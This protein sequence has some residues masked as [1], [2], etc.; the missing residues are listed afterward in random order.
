MTKT[1]EG[2]Q[3]SFNEQGALLR[4]RLTPAPQ[5]NT[6]PRPDPKGKRPDRTMPTQT[7]EQVPAPAASSK[8]TATPAPTQETPRP[9]TSNQT[10]PAR[11]YTDAASRPPPPQRK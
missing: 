4:E 8:P 2:L 11:S 10:K 1:M 5:G 3:K 7:R 9:Q 6:K